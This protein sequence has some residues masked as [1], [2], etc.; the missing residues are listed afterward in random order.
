MRHNRWRRGWDRPWRNGTRKLQP[1]NRSYFGFWIRL[2]PKTAQGNRFL[3]I[4][5]AILLRMEEEIKELLNQNR[6]LLE[7]LQDRNNSQHKITVQFEK[8]NEEFENFDSFIERFETYLDVQNVSE[9][10]RAKVFISSLSPKLYQLLKNLIAPDIP[11]EKDLEFLKNVLKKH[12]TPKP[13]IIPSRHRFLNRK[14]LEGESINTYIAEL[15]AL[16][17]NCDYDNTMLNV[18]LRDVFVSGLR[19]KAILDTEDT[20]KL[21]M[22]FT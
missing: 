3:S 2:K 15:R 12:L 1:V 5:I 4:L 18:M 9:A 8:F 10:Q 22:L 16:A 13:L 6:V 20:G 17:R 11:S 21:I 7:A 19:D 14:Q